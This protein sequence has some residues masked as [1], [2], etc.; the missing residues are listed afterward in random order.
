MKPLK[1]GHVW[2]LKNLPVIESCPL[3]GGNLIKIVTF[4]TKYFVRYSKIM[5]ELATEL[6]KLLHLFSFIP[7]FSTEFMWS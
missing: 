6:V 3:L 2:V 7:D 1:N 5:T 4:G